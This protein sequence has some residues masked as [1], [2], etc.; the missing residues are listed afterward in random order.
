LLLLISHILLHFFF[1]L[2]QPEHWNLLAV[3]SCGI[4]ETDQILHSNSSQK[5]SS[6]SYHLSLVRTCTFIILSHHWQRRTLI[7][8]ISLTNSTSSTA[9]LS[10][11]TKNPV[12]VVPFSCVK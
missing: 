7:V 12:V 3:F 2:V 6:T 1:G 8:L 10:L 4:Y 5:L 9:V 11:L